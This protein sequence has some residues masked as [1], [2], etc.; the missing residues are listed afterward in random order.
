MPGRFV[1]RWT[2]MTN[3]ASRSAA[4]V[5]VVVGLV[6][7]C[8]AEPAVAAPLDAPSAPSAPSAPA[9]VPASK[10]CKVC[11]A[12]K[13]CGNSCISRSKNCHKGRGC[14]CEAEELCP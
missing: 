2:I 6:V 4:C 13:A 9:C 11:D 12:G 7:A 3:R 14:A 5:V 10:C 1:R 8:F